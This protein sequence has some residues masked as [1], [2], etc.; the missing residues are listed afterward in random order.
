MSALLLKPAT[1]SEKVRL[2]AALLL[3][4]LPLSDMLNELTVGAKLSIVTL[5]SLEKEAENLA[6]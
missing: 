1:A 5:S 4:G 6:R 2:T 3:I